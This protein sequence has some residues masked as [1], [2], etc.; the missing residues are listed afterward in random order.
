M[1]ALK[2]VP[3]KPRP[4]RLVPRG[5][6]MTVAIKGM[7]PRVLTQ[8]QAK[9]FLKGLAETRVTVIGTLDRDDPKLGRCVDLI[10]N[11]HTK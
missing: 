2:I 10:V 7:P 4:T 3:L 8:A 1:A 9:A 5:A 11:V 6:L